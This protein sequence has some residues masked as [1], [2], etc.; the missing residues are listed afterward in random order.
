VN[1]ASDARVLFGAFSFCQQKRHGGRS[2]TSGCLL[3]SAR[4]APS[5]THLAFTSAFTLLSLLRF[6]PR[7]AQRCAQLRSRCANA[8]QQRRACA[9]GSSG[10]IAASA[11]A[12]ALRDMAAGAWRPALLAQNP[13]NSVERG[14]DGVCYF[15]AVLAFKRAARNVTRLAAG[16]H[17][18]RSARHGRQA[19][20]ALP[21]NIICQRWLGGRCCYYAAVYFSASLPAGLP[22]HLT[23]RASL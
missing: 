23:Q 17:I 18:W 8:L 4:I 5:S 7:A 22:P 15:S 9:L 6:L 14:R 19:Q 2:I 3:V 1:H 21:C 12:R 13:L 16:R 11:A 10:R 20:G